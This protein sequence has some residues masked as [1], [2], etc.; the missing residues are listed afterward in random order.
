L[1]LRPVDSSS[2][3]RVEEDAPDKGTKESGDTPRINPG[4]SSFG[5]ISFFFTTKVGGLQPRAEN[6]RDASQACGT[7]FPVHP[8]SLLL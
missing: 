7:G 6:L 1:S 4:D 5:R 8:I 2:W 3:V